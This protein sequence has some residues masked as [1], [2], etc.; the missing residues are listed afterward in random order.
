MMAHAVVENRLELLTSDGVTIAGRG[1]FRI[2]KCLRDGAVP[3]R[4][5]ACSVDAHPRARRQGANALVQG[6]WFRYMPPQEETDMT[7][8]FRPSIDSPAGEQCLDLRRKPEGLAVVGEIKRLD[9]EWI[10]CQEQALP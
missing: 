10:A 5:K 6:K 2:S 7:R 8:R 9:A 3:L 4:F 1:R